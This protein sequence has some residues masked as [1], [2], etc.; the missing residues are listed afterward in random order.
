MIIIFALI[1]I[2]IL[3]ICMINANVLAD[4]SKLEHYW[5]ITPYEKHWE[6]FKCFDPECVKDKSYQCYKFCDH[7]SED[8][9]RENCRMRCLD[10]ADQQFD[11]LKF[12]DYTWNYLNPRFKKVTILGPNYI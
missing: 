4:N 6:I 3:I 1:V 5:D 12:Q 10:Y 9:A 2:A 7:I 11:Y 8:G